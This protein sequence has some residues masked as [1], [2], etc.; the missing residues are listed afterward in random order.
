MK[1][2]LIEKIR[3]N[4]KLMSATV[5]VSVIAAGT[6]SGACATGCPY[7]LVNDPYP[8]QCPRYIDAGNGICNLSQASV[9]SSSSSAASNPTSSNV[10]QNDSTNASAISDQGSGFDSSTFGGSG[11]HYILPMSFFLLGGYLFTHYLFSKGILSQKKHRRI[12][13]VLVTAG[14]IGT[15]ITGVF[16]TLIVNLGIRTALNPSISFWH[17]ELAIVMVIGTLIHMHIYR[18]PLKKMLKVLFGFNSS[19]KKNLD[20]SAGNSK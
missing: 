16:L 2:W 14:Y 17:A 7:G 19:S 13:N 15:G 6:I 9:A 18:K 20:E 5:T 12:W 3:G 11:G 1:Q 8:G 10:D 4:E